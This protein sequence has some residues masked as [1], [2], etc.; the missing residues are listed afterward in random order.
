MSGIARITI[1]DITGK[2]IHTL[3]N[4]YLK[5]G[6]HKFEWNADGQNG[7]ARGMYFY[8]IQINDERIVQKFVVF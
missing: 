1:I 8:S 7:L 5:P 4:G 3:H 2:V 6:A